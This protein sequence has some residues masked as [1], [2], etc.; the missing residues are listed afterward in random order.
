M[1]RPEFRFYLDCALQRLSAEAPRWYTRVARHL[2]GLSI[3]VTVESATVLLRFDARVHRCESEGVSIVEISAERA[4]LLD[5]IDGEL[6]L[7]EAI[8][9]DRMFVRGPVAAVV[10]FDSAFSTFLDG[11]IRSRSFPLLVRS[12]RNGTCPWKAVRRIEEAP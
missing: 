7:H 3:A 10:R 5:L 2:D 1:P 9:S 8:R 11:A 12:L 4:T 6:A